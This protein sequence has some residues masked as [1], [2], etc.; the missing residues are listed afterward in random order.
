[1]KS[2]KRFLVIIIMTLVTKSSLAQ[3]NFTG[4]FMPTVTLN[5]SLSKTISQ[6]FEIENRNFIFQENELDFKVKHLEFGYQAKY[7]LGAN[8][9]LGFGIRYRTEMEE[10]EENELR[11]IQQYEWKKHDKAL[12]KHRIRVEE[13]IYDSNVKFRFRYK[14]GASFKTKVFCDQ[15]YIA[16]ELVL[17]MAKPIKPK[18]ENRFYAEASWDLSPKSKLML[19]AQYRLE[20]FTHT[21]HHNLFLTTGLTFDL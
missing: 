11:L 1:M 3:S 18:Y 8:E 2:L 17:T 20:N 19:G 21:A 15:V 9:H 5:H 6:S 13:R 10:G 4:Y 12:L 7:R 14:A 16:N